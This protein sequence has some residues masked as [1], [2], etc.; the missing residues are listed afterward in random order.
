M[1]LKVSEA[2]KKARV[3]PN[4]IRRWLTTG[5]LKGAKLPTSKYNQARWFI[6]EKDL[7]DFLENI[8]CLKDIPKD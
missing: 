6:K 8:P 5:V 7:T 2:A 3:H 4:T 1:Y